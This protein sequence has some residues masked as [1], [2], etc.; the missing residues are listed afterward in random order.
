M[1]TSGSCIAWVSWPAATR[2][3]VPQILAAV[4][5]AKNPERYGLDK[6]TP[7]PPVIYD[8]VSHFVQHRPSPRCRCHRLNRRR[9]C[10]SQSFASPLRPR[11]R[12][13]SFDLHIPTGTRALYDARLKDIPEDRRNS[14]RFHIVKV[15]ETIAGIAAALHAKPEDIAETNGITDKD[16]MAVGDELVVPVQSVT[17]AST[18][19]RYIVRRGD[20]L[21]SIGDRF[22]ITSADL[23][24]WNAASSLR[25]KPGKAIFVAEPI[26]LAHA[27]RARGRRHASGSK[28]RGRASATNTQR[29]RHTSV[30]PGKHA[31]AHAPAS[32]SHTKGR[33]G[34][35]KAAR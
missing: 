24:R 23:H 31:S 34:R 21:L 11:P 16:P 8:T 4:L 26:H 35:R 13:I 9:A 3:Y 14:W 7:S 32:S 22:N 18:P 27:S 20:T 1:P 6:L 10:R 28:A 17:S 12:D 29:G 30:R 25:L 33:A 5:M 19:Q 2:A 15:G